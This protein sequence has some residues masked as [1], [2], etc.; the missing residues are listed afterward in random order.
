LAE[1]DALLPHGLPLQQIAGAGA[2]VGIALRGGGGG[3][4]TPPVSLADT[5][6]KQLARL[7]QAPREQQQPLGRG[8]ARAAD[9]EFRAVGGKTLVLQGACKR[10]P[11][12]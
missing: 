5:L 10:D 2:A 9:S 8:R 12:P 6:S 3:G 11:L 1:A 7:A 4:G